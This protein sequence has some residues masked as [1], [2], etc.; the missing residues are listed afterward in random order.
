MIVDESVG[1]QVFNN[2]GIKVFDSS[3]GNYLVLHIGTVLA[4]HTGNTI[5]NLTSCVD[6]TEFIVYIGFKELRQVNIDEPVLTYV[7]DNAAKLVTISNPGIIHTQSFIV[8]GR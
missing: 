6:F 4:T 3:Y 1:L 8:M 2:A 7:V 5:V